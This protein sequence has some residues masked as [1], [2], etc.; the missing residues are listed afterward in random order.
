MYCYAMGVMFLRDCRKPNYTVVPPLVWALGTWLCNVFYFES[1]LRFYTAEAIS[2]VAYIMWCSS[3]HLQ[4]GRKY[5]LFNVLVRL[6]SL[7]G[8]RLFTWTVLA[9]LAVIN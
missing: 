6:H 4:H 9:V 8:V 5:T 2:I 3:I 7:P 1:T